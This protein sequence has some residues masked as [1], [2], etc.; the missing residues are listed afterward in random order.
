[1]KTPEITEDMTKSIGHELSGAALG[2]ARRTQRAVATLE[3]ISR[4]PDA[5]FP[6][7]LSPAQLEAHYRFTNNH[8]IEYA[9]LFNAHAEE[10]F[11][12]AC[13]K[14]VLVLHDTTTFT[15][16][17][18]KN[19]ADL[20]WVRKRSKK[21]DP[22][23]KKLKTNNEA[24]GFF[25]HFSMLV[26]DDDT[27][28]PL[29]IVN[30]SPIN[31]TN[32]PRKQKL[33]GSD[34]AKKATH[35]GTRWLESIEAVES[36]A[37]EMNMIHVADREG[38][39]IPLM[40][41]ELHNQQRFVIR[42]SY[43]RKIISED[44]ALLKEALALSKS[45]EIYRSVPVS[46]RKKSVFSNANKRHPP[47]SKHI[48]KLKIRGT[49]V[50][51]QPPL[52]FKKELSIPMHINVVHVLEVNPLKDEK[53]VEWILYT[54]E[55]IGTAEELERVVDIYNKR[56][57]IEEFFKALKTGCQYEKRQAESYHALLVTLALLVPMAW[58]L[59]QIRSLSREEQTRPVSEILSA[60]QTSLLQALTPK[61]RLA[62]KCTA[63]EALFAIAELGGHIK[64]NGDPGWLV[65]GRGLQKLLD[66]EVGWRAAMENISKL[67]NVI[68]G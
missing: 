39:K 59:L 61:R 1:M 55:P 32:E 38:D 45:R 43:N 57:L 2:D 7:A 3:A 35:E 21:T 51:L 28:E 16:K 62:L 40:A 50:E 13:G 6:A 29:G 42:A 9:A 4:D 63:R 10:A 24:Y 44:A 47:R 27:F 5:S 36:K 18:G 15:F 41:Y 14:D 37:P 67:K 19:R 56:W 12:R 17:D 66:A 23:N 31:R 54:T 46:K 68:D 11:K 65:L 58:K 52:Y 48:A 53:P 25:G 64:N 26:R 33:N 20:G 49:S 22:K 8:N 60:Q 34:Y 30:M